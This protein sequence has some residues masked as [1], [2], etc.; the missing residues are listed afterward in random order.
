[1]D[2]ADHMTRSIELAVAAIRGADP[3]CFGDPSPCSEHTVEQTVSHLAFGLLLAQR[4]ADRQAWDPEWSGTE[5]APYLVG[6]PAERWA[7]LAARQGEATA[8][9][10]AG[11]QTWEGETTFGGGAM[12]AAAVGSMM[13]A[14]FAVHAWDVAVA[15]GQTLDVPAALGETVLEGVNGMAPAGREGGW[16]APEVKAPADATA[17]ERA[18]AASG[19]NPRWTPPV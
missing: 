7:E 3:A 6:E 5:T 8:R 1:M 13:T 2:Y 12:P 11:P 4:A 15:T 17:F 18:L 10:W 14:E 16:F 9:A 19:R